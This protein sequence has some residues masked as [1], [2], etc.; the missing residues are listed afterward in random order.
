MN[1]FDILEKLCKQHNTNI[2]NVLKEIGLSGSKGTAWRKGSIPKGKIL[3]EIAKYFN[4]SVD[5]L[6]GYS[7]EPKK[8]PKVEKLLALADVLTESQVDILVEM[9]KKFLGSKQ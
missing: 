3:I 1:F 5:Y 6:L 2:T 9:S 7:P 4:V 8:D